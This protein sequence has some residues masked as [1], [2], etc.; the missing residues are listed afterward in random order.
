VVLTGSF[1]PQDAENAKNL[2]RPDMRVKPIDFGSWWRF[3]KALML[4]GQAIPKP[5][6][7]SRVS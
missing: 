1:E 2:A 6:D 4:V 3:A 7:C 5:T